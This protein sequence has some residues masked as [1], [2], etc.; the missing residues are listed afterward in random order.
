MRAVWRVLIAASVLTIVLSLGAR[1]ANKPQGC[2]V[3]STVFHGW[4]AEQVSNRWITLTFVPQLGGRLMQVAFGPHKYLFVNPVFYGKY[5]PPSK[6]AA[7]GKWFN[8]GGDKDWPLP[9]GNQDESHWRGDSDT[10]DDGVYAVKVLS[11][12][13]VCTVSLQGPADVETGLQY[14]RR[15]S[16]SSDSPRISFHAVMKNA[17]GHTIRWSIQSVSQY[18]TADPDHA[19]QYNHNFWAFTPV[20][21]SSVFNRQFD[22]HSGPVDHPGYH[23]RDGRMFALHWC[24]LDGEVGI[25]STA[26]WLAVVDG[27]S[28]YA[29][30]ER[31]SFRPHAEYP[32]RSSTIFYINGPQLRLD[33]DGMPRMTPTD[34]LKTPYYMEAELNSPLV[35]LGPGESYAFDTEWLPTRAT[36]SLTT[37]NDA[38]AV[39]RPLKATVENGGVELLGSFGVFYPGRL[40]ARFY[41]PSGIPLGTVTIMEVS[42]FQLIS[43]RR[44]VSAP[45]GSARI[46]LHLIDENGSDRGSLGEVHISGVPDNRW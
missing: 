23:V 31:M 21:P 13:K 11:A 15:V 29:M 12:G 18:S 43:L 34:P 9:E 45:A 6:G 37:V 28:S 35:E 2:V 19:E 39:N 1:A 36:P 8:Y 16:I 4:A 42:P 20:N 5:F 26:G 41:S 22:V 14:S 25:D 33:K 3:Q 32:E 44:T 38:G 40:A 10:L 30:V 24:Y 27:L 7:R 46:S 17:S